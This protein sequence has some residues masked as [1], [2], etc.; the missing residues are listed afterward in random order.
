[1]LK[2]NVIKKRLITKC[3]TVLGLIFVLNL[4]LSTHVYAG[5]FDFLDPV[6]NFKKA[7]RGF[8]SD[9]ATDFANFAFEGMYKYVVAVTDLSKIPNLQTLISWSQTAGG[10]LV[11]LF[12]L[13][14]VVEG[15]KNEATGEDSTN[16]AEIIGSTV[17]AFALVFATPYMIEYL[18]IPINNLGVQS[19]VNLGIDVNIAGNDFLDRYT[20]GADLALASL[21]IIFMVLVWVIAILVFAVAGAIRYVDLAIVMVM[22]PLVATSYTN[23]SQVYATYWVEVVSVIFTQCIHAL[24]CYL[25]LQ[26]SSGGTLM[27]IIFAIA[28][29][30]VAIRGPQV[31]RQFLYSSGAGSGAVGAG[32]MAAYKMLIKGVGK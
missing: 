13:K 30:V 28:G 19:I 15:M 3:A 11:T 7:V 24:L 8:L 18:I 20:V 16:F 2:N 12:F 1:M 32:R 9:L 29:A 14:R 31:L 17:I 27:G 10:S 5:V 4:A 21:H 6:A 22:G 25:I 23:R 26:W